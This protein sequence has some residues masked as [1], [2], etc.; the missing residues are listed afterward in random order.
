MIESRKIALLFI[1]LLLISITDCRPL[2]SIGWYNKGAE[3][4][5]EGLYG[6]ALVCF[7]YAIR[8]NPND[9][10]YYW[11]RGR[12]YRHLTQ[13]EY[14]IKDFTTA[15]SLDPSYADAYY[16]MGKSYSEIDNYDSALYNYS[17]AIR[18]SPDNAQY[19]CSRGDLYLTKGQLEESRRDFMK[20]C[21][22]GE[23]YGCYCLED[24]WK[25]KSDEM[26]KENN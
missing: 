6:K 13:Y 20:C 26:K 25:E 15:V 18:L 14:A 1:A 21:E 9:A 8:L 3:Y 2:G 17:E 11:A 4:Y 19:Y 10:E 16:E 23:S 22:L 7:N 24:R 12:V 5:N